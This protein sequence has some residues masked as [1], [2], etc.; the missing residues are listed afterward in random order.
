M[1]ETSKNLLRVLVILT[2]NFDAESRH[3]NIY[4]SGATKGRLCM[5]GQDRDQLS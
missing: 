2:A 1:D 5:D 4:V 3:F